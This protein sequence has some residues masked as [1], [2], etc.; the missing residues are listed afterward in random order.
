[1]TGEAGEY[2]DVE[3]GDSRALDIRA[4]PTLRVYSEDGEVLAQHVGAATEAQIRA[5]IDG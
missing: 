1:V 3:T 5:L 2:V 4:V